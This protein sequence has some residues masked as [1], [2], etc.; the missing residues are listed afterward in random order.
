[1]GTIYFGHSYFG[2]GSLISES[3]GAA[4]VDFGLVGIKIVSVEELT[5]LTEIPWGLGLPYSC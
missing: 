1:M 3:E 2:V 4:T 5:L